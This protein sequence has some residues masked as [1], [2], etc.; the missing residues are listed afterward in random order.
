MA[1]NED[2]LE[3]G[4]D[5]VGAVLGNVWNNSPIS[6][7]VDGEN[8]VQAVKETANNDAIGKVG[9]KTIETVKNWAIA[10]VSAALG[11]VWNNS[12]ISK[13]VDG[14]N[15][16]QAVKE[17]ANNDAIGKVG[18]KTI[19][20][21]KN[22][23]IAAVSAASSEASNAKVKKPNEMTTKELKEAQRK[24]EGEIETYNNR[25]GEIITSKTRERKQIDN[26]LRHR[27][28]EEE[29]L[30]ELQR[31]KAAL[32]KEIKDKGKI[33]Q[34]GRGVVRRDEQLEELNNK[35]AERQKQYNADNGIKE[36]PVVSNQPKNHG[37]NE[38]LIAVVAPEASQQ[39]PKYTGALLGVGN[40][41]ESVKD[42]QTKLGVKAD[43]IYG[44]N[45]EAAVKRF[46]RANGL[47]DDGVVGE[48]TATALLAEEVRLNGVIGGNDVKNV[49]PQTF[50]D[51]ATKANG[52]I[53]GFS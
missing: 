10:A 21:V 9:N 31:Q 49:T 23:A 28:K 24:H 5:F 44:K 19:E 35:I 34:V 40:A 15:P 46:Q 43:G 36:T 50:E 13:I 4:K 30:A 8:P 47:D 33:S 39:Q 27:E 6:K 53:I 29:E 1:K 45:T 3:T 11:N 52:T 12:P 16:V 48:K 18:N 38:D 32:E 20:T 41:D 7:I 51:K 26:E 42:L 17:T 25:T 14:E 22:W 2:V 37:S